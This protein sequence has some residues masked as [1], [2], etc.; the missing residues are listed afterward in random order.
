MGGIWNLI[1]ILRATLQHH[2]YLSFSHIP[3]TKI[4]W[5]MTRTLVRLRSK[6]CWYC[7]AC[8]HMNTFFSYHFCDI[9]EVQEYACYFL[10]KVMSLFPFLIVIISPCWIPLAQS[11]TVTQYKS[12]G[13]FLY[14]PW[15]HQQ[16][17]MGKKENE[18][19]EERYWFPRRQELHL[20][21]IILSGK[22]L[23]V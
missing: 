23:F 8:G 1:L 19:R 3:G 16:K 7:H 12:S 21:I 15:Q 22:N 20:K 14:W 5:R 11:G 10:P 6:D 13:F 9:M 2:L 17:K 18:E 4:L